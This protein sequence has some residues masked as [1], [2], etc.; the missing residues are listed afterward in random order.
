MVYWYIMTSW[1][2]LFSILPIHGGGLA[3]GAY[4][5]TLAPSF[6]GLHAL[7][8]LFMGISKSTGLSKEAKKHCCSP[9]TNNRGLSCCDTSDFSAG[10]PGYRAATSPLHTHGG[11]VNRH[12]RI[13]N[14][15]IKMYLHV[16]F[17]YCWIIWISNANRVGDRRYNDKCMIINWLTIM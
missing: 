11:N 17:L 9:Q 3:E 2:R 12:W 14:D 7:I 16:V 13:K 10:T 5:L 4:N 1:R 6:A 8:F 15:T